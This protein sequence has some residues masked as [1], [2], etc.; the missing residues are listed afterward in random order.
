MKG[1]KMTGGSRRLFYFVVGKRNKILMCRE[2]GAGT[3]REAENTEIIS[4]L[5]Y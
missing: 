4:G 1:K 5:R 2:K 3:E